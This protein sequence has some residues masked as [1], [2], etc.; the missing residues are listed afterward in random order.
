MSALFHAEEGS[1]TYWRFGRPPL[2]AVVE[3]LGIPAAH[4]AYV[5]RVSHAEIPGNGPMLDADL[6]GVAVDRA[7]FSDL[8]NE[9]LR[10]HAKYKPIT[11]C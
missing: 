10:Y 7:Y 2:K 3:R 6:D 9:I 11:A 5:Q 4:F 1:R 8:D